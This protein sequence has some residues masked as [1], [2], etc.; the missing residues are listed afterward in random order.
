LKILLALAKAI[1]GI[2][3]TKEKRTKKADFL[4]KLWEIIDSPYLKDFP[5]YIKFN[6]K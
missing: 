3:N 6:K 4:L 5:D 2:I 1:E